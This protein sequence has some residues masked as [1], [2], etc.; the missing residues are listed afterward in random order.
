MKFSYGN[1]KGK[2]F[3]AEEDAFLLYMTHQ[4][5]YGNW[6]ALKAEIRKAWQFRFDWYGIDIFIF[7]LCFFH[8]L[9]F[10]FM[11]VFL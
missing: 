5:G 7:D 8:F 1:A 4:L 9:Y 2:A 10:S 11:N 3:T 6:D